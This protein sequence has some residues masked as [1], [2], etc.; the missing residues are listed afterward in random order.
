MDGVNV[1]ATETVEYMTTGGIVALCVIGLLIIVGFICLVIS[2]MDKYTNSACYSG[3]LI[4]FFCFIFLLMFVLRPT[5]TY[6]Y[7]TIEDTV[8]YIEFSEEYNVEKRIGDLYIATKL[9]K[10]D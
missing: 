6:Y 4:V 2:I 10:D 9:E 5:K 8:N 3:A 1:L 7:L